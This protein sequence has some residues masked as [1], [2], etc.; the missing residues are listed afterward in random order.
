MNIF[1]IIQ[2]AFAPLSSRDEIN[3]LYLKSDRGVVSRLAHGNVR[4]Q[5]GDF[6]T[7]EDLDELY[8]RVEHTTFYP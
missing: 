2:G 5:L 6:D 1:G 7:R 3:S 8:E 4:I